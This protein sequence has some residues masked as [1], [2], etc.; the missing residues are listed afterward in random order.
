V[1]NPISSDIFPAQPVLE[2]R[3]PDANPARSPG[4]G[5]EKRTPLRDAD[6]DRAHQRLS[7]ESADVFEP[8]IVSVQEAKQ[9]V[10]L[11]K[12]LMTEAPKAA[13]KAHGNIKAPAF[14]AAM[15]RP[16]V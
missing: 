1:A 7:Q 12:D 2:Q 15:A 10:A 5:F 16:A 6:L 9:R 14:E 13:A 4:P 11:L 8:A 3:K